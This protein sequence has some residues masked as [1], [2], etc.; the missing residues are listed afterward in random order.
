M[1]KEG[2]IVSIQGYNR[3]TI[4]ELT[5][6]IVSAGAVAIRTDKEIIKDVV[7]IGLNKTHVNNPETEAYITP[8]MDLVSFVS[9][10]ADYVAVDYRRCNPNLLEISETSKEKKIKI[11]ADIE[12]IE[13]FDNII[14][15]KYYYDYIATTFSVFNPK[16][17]FYPD[18]D[19]A[20]EIFS[21]EKHLIAEGNIA[22]REQVRKLLGIGIKHICI[23][24]AISNIYKLTRKFT[25]ILH[26]K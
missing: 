23:G 5:D 7:K 21:H 24:S 20:K 15:H 9:E 17:R 8:T 4:E 12:N 1:L 14:K 16:K 6:N 10:W 25:T 2:I 13:D 11:I 18:I 19:L 3:K 26:D 22:T